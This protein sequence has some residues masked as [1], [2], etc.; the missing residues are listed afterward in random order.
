[1]NN[2]IK[3]IDEIG[4]TPLRRDALKILE[5][6]YEAILT[7]N[8]LHN[9][10]SIQEN[11]AIFG[12]EP[13]SIDLA[14]CDR[15]FVAA[16]GKCAVDAGIAL[17]EILGDRITD[18]VVV[19]I[20]SGDFKKL[21]SFV[22]T[23]PYP[24]EQNVAAAKEIVAMISNLTEKDLLI[25]II[26]GGG[27]SLLSL[28]HDISTDDL[29]KITRE[30]MDKG[31]PIRELNIVR[32]HLSDIQGGQL[33]KIAFP[34][35]VIS[36]IFSDVPG[37]DLAVIAS[38]PTI[39]DD[40]MRDEAEA[41]LTKYNIRSAVGMPALETIETPKEEKYFTNVKNM[42]VVTNEVALQAMEKKAASLGYNAKIENDRVE[43][44]AREFGEELARKTLP[45][46]TCLLYG[47]E[48]TV[49]VSAH[50]G[51]GGRNQEFVLGGLP[52]L[53][54]DMV[55]VGA[56]SDGKDYSD[57]GGAIGD[58]E[59]FEKG[60]AMGLDTQDFLANNNSFEY[61]KRVV[62]HIHTGA[63]GANVADLY[64]IVKG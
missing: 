58:K 50:P 35:K 19:D 33:A 59:L 52:Y 23:H 46:K 6:G 25:M 2:I 12:K 56:S 1:M 26:S 13:E 34:A 47:G 42:L 53:K 63:T 62:G 17:E 64:F 9:F 36:L 38:G 55:L 5:A 45:P 22:G 8:A 14:A 11:K 61:F 3:N 44:I 16:I 20:K 27:S 39:M 30:I 41:I 37:N 31:A 21:R 54:E 18:G 32:K 51:I 48:T 4:I 57:A 15:I 40:S 10:I 49:R 29:T 28:P 7:S 43:G 60:K 24:S